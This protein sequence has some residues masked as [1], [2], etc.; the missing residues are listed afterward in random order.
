MNSEL[1]PEQLFWQISKEPDKFLQMLYIP[2]YVPCLETHRKLGKNEQFSP[3]LLCLHFIMPWLKHLVLV[4]V[5]S[6]LLDG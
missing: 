2:G 4:T 1:P 3:Q 5:K 6:K